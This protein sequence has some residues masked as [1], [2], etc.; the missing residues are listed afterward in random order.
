[1]LI[2]YNFR[3]LLA[4]FILFFGTNILMQCP[5]SVPVCCMF[6]VSQKPHIKRSPNGI[7]TDRELFWNICDFWEVKSTRDGA[8]GGQEIGAHAHSRWARP[9]P[10]GPLVRK[11]MPFFGCKKANFRRRIL[12]EVSIQSELRI[13]GYITNGER[14]EYQ[15]AETER[16]RETDPILEGLSPLPCHGGHGPEGKPFYH[17]G[18][19]SRKNNKKGGLSPPLSRWCRNAAGAIIV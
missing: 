13:S 6:Y 9:H 17:L 18:R 16:D 12:A 5:V 19:R 10:P 2:F 8:R 14:A 4:T 15:N 11:L 3:I 7:K 1:M